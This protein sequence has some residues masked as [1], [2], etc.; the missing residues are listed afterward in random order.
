L[1]R[2]GAA[3]LVLSLRAPQVRIDPCLPALAGLAISLHD[4]IVQSKR[5]RGFRLA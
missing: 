2:R 4:I 3:A 5:D 1:A